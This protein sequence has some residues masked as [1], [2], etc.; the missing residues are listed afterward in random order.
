MAYYIPPKN[1]SITNK[2]AKFIGRLNGHFRYMLT[3]MMGGLT[4]IAFPPAYGIFFLFIPF[5]FLIWL[6]NDSKS[7]MQ[8]F[9]DGWWFG[10]GMFTISLAWIIR[11]LQLSGFNWL[12]I[13]TPIIFGLLMGL[14]TGLS[15]MLASI[16]NKGYQR[17]LMLGAM[18]ALGEW[19][20]SW[21]FTGF[22]WNLIGSI[23]TCN[24]NIIQI[25]SVIG[26]YGL[27]ALTI[28]LFCLPSLFNIQRR[29]IYEDLSDAQKTDIKHSAGNDKKTAFTFIL[30][31]LAVWTGIYYY[32]YLRLNS[33]GETQ[34]V[35]DVNLRLVQ[36]NIRQEDK[37]NREK[38]IEN[39]DKYVNLSKK[40]GIENITH[41]IWGETAATFPVDKDPNIRHKMTKWLAE[42][43][44]LITGFPRY[45]KLDENK[46]QT[47]NSMAVLDNTGNMIELYNKFHLVPFGEYIPLRSLFGENIEKI[48]HGMKDFTSGK[49]L[50]T[51]NIKGLPPTSALICYEII[52]PSQV[53]LNHNRPEAIINLT[54]D[55]WYGQSQ[56]PYEHFEMA[57][58]RAAEEGI[59]VVRVANTGISGIIDAYG[60]VT[61]KTKLSEENVLDGQLPKATKATPYGKW[62]NVIP[63]LLILLITIAALIQKPKD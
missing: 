25:T 24:D 42:D 57:R 41:V 44:I 20:R 11:A 35:D 32:G 10:V 45:K 14:F 17:I 29:S 34:F 16:A 28:I 8:A 40:E 26:T 13:F 21:L 19:L 58:L 63:L 4:T 50:R 3:A 39:F 59:P 60:R 6:L 37:W 2:I 23:W 38:Y 47:W 9:S 49:G 22:P 7:R 27:S 31:T 53:A 1:T 51:L 33:A 12:A 36:P 54:N 15:T 43:A 18:W 62:G 55:A 48:T 52:F 56:G 5:T 46:Y 30:V 61:T